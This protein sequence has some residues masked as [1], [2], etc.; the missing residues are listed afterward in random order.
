MSAGLSPEELLGKVAD[1]VGAAPVSLTEV[2]TSSSAGDGGD[3]QESLGSDET[4]QLLV[5]H[6]AP[7]SVRRMFRRGQDRSRHHQAFVIACVKAGM[8]DEAIVALTAR[9]KPSVDKYAGRVEAETRRSI[10]HAREQ[11]A[12]GGDPEA[13]DDG[14]SYEAWQPVDL[15]PAWRGE[16]VEPEAVTLERA[17]GVRLF[18]AGVNYLF[19]DSGDGKSWIVLFATVQLLRAGRHV[20]WITYEDPSELEMVKRLRLLGVTEADL[21]RLSLIVASEAMTSGVGA[22]GRLVRRHQT[23]LVVLDSVGEALAVDG[24]DEDRD[25]E[26]GPWARG[27][28]R[29]L[30]DVAASTTWDEAE[31][32]PANA[33]LA[34]VPIDHSTKAKDN[35]FYPSGTKRKRAMVTGTMFMLNVREAFAAGRVGRVQLITAKDRTGRFRRGEIAA[36]VMLDATSDPYTV[37]IDPPPAG[38]EMATATKRRK[39]EDRIMVVLD[40]SNAEMSVEDIHRLVNHADSK[41]DGEGDLSLGAVKNAMTKLA[42]RP[43]VRRRKEPTGTGKAFRH[44]YVVEN[45]ESDAPE[46]GS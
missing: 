21:E 11:L 7:E 8:S 34:V 30:L 5:Q 10:E 27:T 24:V 20:L 4:E 31:D 9:F 6:L 38:G 40:G 32:T 25:A 1:A 39:A 43:N 13:D 37:A 46:G 2:D 12:K 29:L 18:P 35:P 45:H 44:L 42:K 41:F 17:D 3:T 15:L 28:V 16:R 22:L 19:G 36:E 26:F 33:A 14:G 23:A